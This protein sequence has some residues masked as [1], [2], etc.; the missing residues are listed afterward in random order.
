MSVGFHGPD[1]LPTCLWRPPP[2]RGEPGWREYPRLPLSWQL[3]AASWACR[4]VMEAVGGTALPRLACRSRQC[5]AWRRLPSPSVP[6]QLPPHPAQPSGE[7]GRAGGRLC[8]LG[9]PPPPP[10]ARSPWR[11]TP[12]RRQAGLGLYLRGGGRRGTNTKKAEEVPLRLLRLPPSSLAVKCNLS[13]WPVLTRQWRREWRRS[14]APA[15]SPWLLLLSSAHP[16]VR[17]ALDAWWCACW[18]G[19]AGSWLAGLGTRVLF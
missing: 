6:P 3:G 16:R 10:S 2:G 12:G 14:P 1:G 18:G 13:R 11:V 7:G 17:L 4:E 8:L 19:T 5:Q 15:A 9:R